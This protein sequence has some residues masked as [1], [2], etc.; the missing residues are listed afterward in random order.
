MLTGFE[1]AADKQVP[2][3]DG[4]CNSK[5]QPCMKTYVLSYDDA[6]ACSVSVSYAI[7][8]PRLKNM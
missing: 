6:E 4:I 8:V 7:A 2:T 3:S 5:E 1:G